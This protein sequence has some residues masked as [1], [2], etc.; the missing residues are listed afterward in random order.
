MPSGKKLENLMKKVICIALAVFM[1]LPMLTALPVSAATPRDGFTFS[2]SEWYYADSK[3]EKAPRTFEAWIY[4]NPG[5]ETERQT[6][7]SNYNGFTSVP[8]F[9]FDLKYDQGVLFPYLEWNELYNNGTSLRKFNFREAVITAGKW[10]H[11]AVV[12]DAANNYVSCYKD[13]EHIQNNGGTLTL[14]NAS[15]GGT[16]VTVRLPVSQ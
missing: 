15:G 8:F 11:I 12:I 13:G 1:L 5:H 2:D 16:V 3:L 4:V 6:I 10:T 7:I 9:H 14:E